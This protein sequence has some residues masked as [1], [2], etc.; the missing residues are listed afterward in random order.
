MSFLEMYKN[1]E[2]K[3][4]MVHHVYE[5]IKNTYE[6]ILNLDDYPLISSAFVGE[7]QNPELIQLTAMDM[8]IIG[9]SINDTVVKLN[10]NKI[11]L[12]FAVI[13]PHLIYFGFDDILNDNI[14]KSM[15]LEKFLGYTIM[16]QLLRLS[17]IKNKFNYFKGVKNPHDV[18][19]L[20]EPILE[21]DES[22]IFHEKEGIIFHNYID[23]VSYDLSR[24]YIAAQAYMNVTG[25]LDK[26]NESPVA[27]EIV[28]DFLPIIKIICGTDKE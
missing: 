1:H 17:T 4:E 14:E 27:M 21:M 22:M 9:E 13:Y 25:S 8:N 2:I 20:C 5:N 28:N 3:F 23:Y 18:N 10:C 26:F 24:L 16:N 19:K 6:R 12:N 15:L 11:I 7:S